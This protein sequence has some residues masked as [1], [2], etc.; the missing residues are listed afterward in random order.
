MNILVMSVRAG[1]GHHS[2]G[3]AIIEYLQ[4]AG[5]RCEMLDIFD[6]INPLLGNSI[7]DGYLL[8]TKYLSQYYGRIYGKLTEKDEPY[9][10]HSITAILSNAVSKRLRQY[11]YEFEPDAIIGTHSYAGVVTT[12][13]KKQKVCTCMTYGIVTDFTVH[14]FWESTELDYYVI[15]DELLGYQM[16][17][18][19][20]DKRTLLPIGIPRRQQFSKK[21]DT[22]EARQKLGIAD[23]Q[24]I[25]IM[26]GSMGYGNVSQSLEVLDEFDADFQVLCVCGSNEK[27]RSMLDQKTYSK[28]IHIYGFV[29]NVDVMMDASD[30]IIS[31]PGGLTT[32]EAFAKGLPMI[33]MNPLPGQEDRNTDFLVN[34]GAV[35]AVNDRFHL[36]EAL[37]QIFNCSWRLDHMNESVKHIG[38][39][40]ST[41]NLCEF[42]IS[43]YLK[44][45]KRSLWK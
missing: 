13:L 19:G 30:I 35:I 7:Q 9:N 37:N 11:V 36:N 23:K 34:C 18:K 14:P 43:N 29:N 24:T 5:H 25:L 8:S 38:K 21:N 32:S 20:I 17:K 40:E 39:P 41:K 3:K 4:N 22:H 10:K 16:Q 12:I 33:T 45:K 1:Y 6:Y 31:K 26:M 27:L 2:T 42:I 15:P 44:K 28:E